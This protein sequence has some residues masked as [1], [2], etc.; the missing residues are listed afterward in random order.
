M[1]S[2]EL[3]F[4]Q[5]AVGQWDSGS[6]LTFSVIGLSE[7]GNVYKY[8]RQGWGKLDTQSSESGSKDTRDFLGNSPPSKDDNF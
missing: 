3:K 1:K 8:T 2:S 4:K 5:I 7:D 6:G